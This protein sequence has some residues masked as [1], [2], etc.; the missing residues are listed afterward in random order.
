MADFEN[1]IQGQA[2]RRDHRE[3]QAETWISEFGALEKTKADK[4]AQDRTKQNEN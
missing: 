1:Q 2:Q 3:L 4:K